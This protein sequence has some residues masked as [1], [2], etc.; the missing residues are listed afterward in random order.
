[1]ITSTA[2]RDGDVDA[3]AENSRADGSPDHAAADARS[4]RPSRSELNRAANEVTRL[5]L[6][7]SGLSQANLNRLELPER[8]REQIDIW[9]KLKPKSRGRQNR[10][11]GQLLRAEDHDAIR[12]RLANLHEGR[13]FTVQHEEVNERWRDRLIEGGDESVE[14]LIADYPEADRQSLRQLTRSARGKVESSRT[15]KARRELLRAIRTLRA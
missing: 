8:V 11:I 14:S 2:P 9:Q 5:G 3:D 4:E 1:M 15:K 7:L 12:A 13:R 10:L 6:E